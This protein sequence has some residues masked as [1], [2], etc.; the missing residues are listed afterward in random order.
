VDYSRELGDANPVSNVTQA[1]RLWQ[2]SGLSEEAF[3]AALR[4][5]KLNVR[6]AQAHGVANKGAYWF[7]VL[8]D[9]LA[10]DGPAGGGTDPA[11]LPWDLLGRQGMD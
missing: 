2:A 7:R 8:R 4:T 1:L 10:L 3:V 11:S 9:Q 5:A 6:T